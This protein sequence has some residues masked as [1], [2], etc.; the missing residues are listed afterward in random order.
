MTRDPL[1]VDLNAEALA[2]ETALRDSLAAFLA[3]DRGYGVSLNR[4]AKARTEPYYN[5]ENRR[6]ES[7][8]A[9]AR[10]LI[11]GID[12]FAELRT[13]LTERVA[14]VAQVPTAAALQASLAM[15]QTGLQLE[16]LPDRVSV[17]ASVAAFLSSL[18]QAGRENVRSLAWASWIGS[19]T[20]SVIMDAAALI[21]VRQ[22]ELEFYVQGVTQV[23]LGLLATVTGREVTNDAAWAV[24]EE[25]LHQTAV[26]ALTTFPVAAIAVGI[27]RIVTGVK[28]ELEVLETSY[29]RNDVDD[30]F[31]FSRRIPA[32]N[33]AAAE[34]RQL[35]VDLAASPPAP[36]P[37]P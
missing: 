34:L 1:T 14:I 4:E 12:E 6:D 18:D 28:R 19:A 25:I 27:V 33:Q 36:P 9:A 22:A 3:A 10:N 26:T 32:T 31:A 11:A 5:P 23:D 29:A 30:M 24:F 7:I 8:Q 13:Q 20:A 21:S 37:E 2:V 16:V 17:R 35:L 15:L